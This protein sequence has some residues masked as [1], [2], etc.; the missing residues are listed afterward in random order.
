M[1]LDRKDL[2]IALFAVV[3]LAGCGVD[4][5]PGPPFSALV[6]DIDQVVDGNP[7]FVYAERQL[8][9]VDDF[10]HLDGALF[11]L[12]RGGTLTA[13]EVS[14][15]LVIDP[16]FSGAD[17]PDLRYRV[18][19]G[20]A[21][22]RDYSTLAMISAAYQLEQVMLSLDQVVGT[23]ASEIVT[24]GRYELLFE[25]TLRQ[26]GEVTATV[27]PKFNAFYL[28]GGVRQFGLA[29]RS[30]FEELPVAVSPL[31]LAHEFGHGL[32]ELS[33]DGGVAASCDPDARN[34]DVL[35]PG[36]LQLEHAISGFNEGWADFVS[37]SVLGTVDPLAGVGFD[38]ESRN[39]DRATYQFADIDCSGADCD[40]G[41]SFY[42]IGTV[43]ARSL[44]EA[45]LAGGGDPTDRASRGAFSTE[46][47][48]ALGGTQASIAAR[49]D[50][51]GDAYFIG[52]DCEPVSFDVFDADHDGAVTSAFLGALVENLEPS[53]RGD[54]CAALI[55][56]FGDAGF[57]PGARD[58]CPGN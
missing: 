40:C 48:G 17:D 36:R 51:P 10:D 39:M 47:F 28:P 32:F 44:Y 19:G 52:A 16:E 20:V 38:D 23:P 3:A 41:G 57:D 22:P 8:E 12:L 13:R 11:R 31:V 33:F 45:F 6:L 56:N 43:F 58:A 1:A 37:F 5:P 29:R 21:I 7:T 53:L 30:Q 50:M 14:G 2:L 49:G 18:E 42:C 26:E 54:V 4:P 9:T 55:A 27:T 15:S 25:P 34:D 24:A 46:I 35:F